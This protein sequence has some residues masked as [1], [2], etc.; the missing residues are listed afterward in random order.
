MRSIAPHA[1]SRRKNIV[2]V[3]GGGSGHHD[4]RRQLE[5][6]DGIRLDG[7][8]I[9]HPRIARAHPQDAI[10]R[11]AVAQQPDDPVG[12]GLAGADDH[13][14]ARRPG[15]SG[16]RVD[17]RDGDVIC[18]LERSRRRGWDGRR[19]I[20]RVDDAASHLH[21]RGLS[22]H[23]RRDEMRFAVL[24]VLASR[25]ERHSPGALEATMED[26]IVVRADLG[27]AR[28]LLQARLGTGR[29][30]RA[31]SHDG[32]R[33]AVEQGRLMQLDERICVEPVSPRGVAAIDERDVDIRVIEEGVG[34][35]HAH[36]PCADDEIV[37][38]Q[39]ARHGS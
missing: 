16:E 14:G 18:H 32:R 36:R 22:G 10:R 9:E 28:A 25:E 37:G 2:D 4:I 38:F 19:E 3:L 11:H 39:R 13:E 26:V 34:E 21:A 35:R 7:G 23:Q 27:D 12:G 5:R 6:H 20:R 31:G 17:R 8:S 33:D 15:Q 30:Q 29:L 1:S 24:A